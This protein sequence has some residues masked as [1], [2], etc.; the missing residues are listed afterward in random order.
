[1]SDCWALLIVSP[2]H[3]MYLCGRYSCVDGEVH[4]APTHASGS[5]P[6]EPG[7]MHLI[8]L[9]ACCVAAL[10]LFTYIC[11]RVL[12]SF[13]SIAHCRASSTVNPLLPKATIILFI[14]LPS[15]WHLVLYLHR[16][17]DLH[18]SIYFDMETSNG[19][20]PAAA[21]RIMLNGLLIVPGV[22]HAVLN[23]GVYLCL[24]VLRPR[25][26]MH[27]FARESHNDR[28]R[29]TLKHSACSH[30]WWETLKGSIF[31]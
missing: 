13:L 19:L 10:I 2:S 21:E 5:G 1:M 15:V 14:S 18:T 6:L 12:H 3:Y 4:C 17:M 23:I 27:G 20:M 16:A 8:T 26:S 31:V 25:G 11:T 24:L 28:T 29:N 30:K 9:E 22:E 7:E